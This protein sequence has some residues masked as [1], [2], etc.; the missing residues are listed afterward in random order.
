LLELVQ[1]LAAQSGVDTD[2]KGL[3]PVGLVADDAGLHL[4]TMAR[5][6]FDRGLP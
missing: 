4:T 1:T 6:A 5:H 2:R 3:I